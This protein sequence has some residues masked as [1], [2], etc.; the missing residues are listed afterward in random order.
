MINPESRTLAWIEK[1]SR[2]NNVKDMGPFRRSLN[3]TGIN[4]HNNF[5]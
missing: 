3:Q 2:E 1:V 5:F 4:M